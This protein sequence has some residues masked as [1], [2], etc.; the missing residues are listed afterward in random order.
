MKLAFIFDSMLYGG[1]E[2]VGISY[3]NMLVD[4]GH[5]IDVYILNEKTEDI[6]NEIN[7]KCNVC[8]IPFSV[9]KCPESY[10]PVAMFVDKHCLEFFYITLN[11]FWHKILLPFEK[12]KLGIKG[13]KY[14]IAIAF[15]GHIKDLT[16]L[17]EGFINCQKKAAWLH[18][19][20]YQY[21]ILS[22]G[23]NRLYAKVKN[24]VCLSDRSDI[25]MQDFNEKKGI[26]KVKIYNPLY[27][28]N[29][30]INSQ[31]CTELRAKY[32]DYIL[33][34]SRIAEDKDQATV[35]RAMDVLKNKYGVKKNLVFVGDG[36]LRAQTEDL[37]KE[38]KL[39]DTVFFEGLRSDVENYYSS[40]YVYVHS[41]PLEG[42]PTVLL[43]AMY[44]GLPVAS[45][46]A[47]PG[48]REILG[49]DEYGLV[50]PVA[51]AEALAEN[52]KRLYEDEE[53]KK[54]L[55]IRS[56]KRLEAFEPKFVLKQAENFFDRVLSEK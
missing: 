41:S 44:Y 12:M 54:E 3:I 32:G 46:D 21:A 27:M 31:K 16:F 20:Q 1:I 28:Q 6:V 4:E 18:G 29:R 42:L 56:E 39:E 47:I 48:V 52:I 5:E 26:N 15:S 35:V 17:A 33:M 25:E 49:N 38:L 50:S 30:K 7:D 14:D 53:L 23:F 24:L 34:V 36:P 45:T 22:P 11:Y 13:K 10:W 40:A 43:E 9:K 51:N 19:A 8:Q 2:R 37:V 55:K